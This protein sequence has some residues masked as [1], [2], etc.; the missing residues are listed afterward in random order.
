[1]CKV[2]VNSFKLIVRYFSAFVLPELV[3]NFFSG[4]FWQFRLLLLSSS[5]P[6]LFWGGGG[7]GGGGGMIGSVC[8]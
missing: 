5:S 6:P 2:C 8:K 1:M 7:G 3:E 4:I